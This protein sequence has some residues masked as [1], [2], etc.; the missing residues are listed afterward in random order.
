M[1]QIFLA[2]SAWT[3][4]IF[5]TACSEIINKE[6][7]AKATDYVV[8]KQGTITVSGDINK[9]YYNYSNLINGTY[10]SVYYPTYDDNLSVGF[11]V[12]AFPSFEEFTSSGHSFVTKFY[13]TS[14]I[15]DD[16]LTINK[17]DFVTLIN[18]GMFYVDENISV[19]IT[20]ASM[21]GGTVYISGEFNAT[22]IGVNSNFATDNNLTLEDISNLE[23]NLTSEK[24]IS[25]IFSNLII[26]ANTNQ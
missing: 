3:S 7:K 13:S 5:F 1:R 21:T 15:E 25:V 4:M 23:D 10:T 9:T 11:E 24:N 20:D 17:L 18:E 19:N 22:M 26:P 8:K 14:L 16:L 12:V 2:V 6:D